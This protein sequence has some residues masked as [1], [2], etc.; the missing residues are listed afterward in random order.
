M[1]AATSKPIIDLDGITVAPP[2]ASQNDVFR[3]MGSFVAA[4]VN[5]ETRLA[6]VQHA[7]LIVSM[8]VS[9]DPLTGMYVKVLQPSAGHSAALFAN[10][11][12]NGNNNTTTT[13]KPPPPLTIKWLR[14]GGENDMPPFRVEAS[15]SYDGGPRLLALVVALVRALGGGRSTAVLEDRSLLDGV[16]AR[17]LRVLGKQGERFYNELGFASLHQTVDGDTYRRMMTTLRA[18]SATKLVAA[19]DARC[20]ALNEALQKASNVSVTCVAADGRQKTFKSASKE[21]Q[22]LYD[23]ASKLAIDLKWAMS[24]LPSQ[25]QQQVQVVQR[26]GGPALPSIVENAAKVD[27]ARATKLVWEL[28]PSSTAGLL[29]ESVDGGSVAVSPE[30]IALMYAASLSKDLYCSLG[31]SPPEPLT[32]GRAPRPP[33][34]RMTKV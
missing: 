30:E 10:A 22:E 33:A 18:A 15:A 31:G 16:P 3:R 21:V 20:A 28:L 6:V 9:L 13:K 7:G 5:E 27:A 19:I 17:K 1:A 24:V 23:H 25:Q 2:V 26:G 14:T 12:N 4:H 11:G 32:G 34:R 8:H 29:V